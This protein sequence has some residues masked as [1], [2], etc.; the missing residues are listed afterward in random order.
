[1]SDTTL[2]SIP[3]IIRGRS[4]NS[5]VNCRNNVIEKAVSPN[6]LAANSSSTADS[7]TFKERTLFIPN[8]LVM[9]AVDIVAGL[10]AAIAVSPF[11][12]TIDKGKDSII[13]TI[14]LCNINILL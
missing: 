8:A 2:P 1:M 5:L 4:V 9:Y 6:R 14:F 7:N 11:L 3:V 13:S 10:L 12:S